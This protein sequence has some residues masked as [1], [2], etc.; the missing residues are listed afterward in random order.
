MAT[1][2]SDETSTLVIRMFVAR[3]GELHIRLI[4]LSGA[5][6]ERVLGTLTS[7]A[8]AAALVRGWIEAAVDAMRSDGVS[9]P[10]ARPDR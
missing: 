8:A 3:G 10:A 6:D 5:D 1:P 4:A 9:A 2:A 7:A